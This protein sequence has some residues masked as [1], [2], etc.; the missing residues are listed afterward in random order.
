[1]DFSLVNKGKYWTKIE[2]VPPANRASGKR[3][4][5]PSPVSKDTRKGAVARPGVI[6]KADEQPTIA[7]DGFEKNNNEELAKLKKI[8]TPLN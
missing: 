6:P 5:S 2:P 7:S 1:M 4:G 8:P 3:A